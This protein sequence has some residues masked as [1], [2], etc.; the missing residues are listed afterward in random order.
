MKKLIYIISTVLLLASAFGANA[1]ESCFDEIAEAKARFIDCMLKAKLG[2]SEAQ[3]NL[4]VMYYQGKVV[5]RDNKKAIEWMTKAAERGF[6]AAKYNL[7][8]WYREGKGV[9]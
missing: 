4:G 5:S 8:K 7:G 1:A 2:L 9:A 3:L 6:V